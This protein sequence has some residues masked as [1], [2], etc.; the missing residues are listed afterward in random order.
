MTRLLIPLKGP[1]SFCSNVAGWASPRVVF[2][3]NVIV[4]G[5]LGK[6]KGLGSVDFL[7]E[8]VSGEARSGAGKV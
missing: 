4:E 2:L 3:L 5:M 7:Y 6:T 8:S 1:L